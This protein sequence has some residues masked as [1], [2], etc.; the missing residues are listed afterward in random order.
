M[1]KVVGGRGKEFGL[2]FERSKGEGVP[3]FDKYKQLGIG[4]LNFGHFVMM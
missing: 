3:K 4:D 1:V 2:S